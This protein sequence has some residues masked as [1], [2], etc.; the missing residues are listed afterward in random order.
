MGGRR[1][2]WMDG[3]KGQMNGGQDQM[4]GYPARQRFLSLSMH[5]K[6]EPLH[7]TQKEKGMSVSQGNGR[8]TDG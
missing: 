7:A 8:K 1:E 3:K 4:E 5:N 6:R 2:G